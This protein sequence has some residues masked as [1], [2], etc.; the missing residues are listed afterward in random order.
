M[1]IVYP[2]LGQQIKAAQREL[3][4]RRT[5]YA[6][7]VAFQKMTQAEAD[8]EVELMAAILKTLEELQQQDLF[9][10]HNPPR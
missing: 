1:P 5:V 2:T 7:R 9:K 10:T 6:K 8:L 4:M 3:A